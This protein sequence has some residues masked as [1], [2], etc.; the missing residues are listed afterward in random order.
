MGWLNKTL[1]LKLE[2]YPRVLY[3]SAFPIDMRTWHDHFEVTTQETINQ[4]KKRFFFLIWQPP[5]QSYGNAGNR[6]F[7]QEKDKKGENWW[8]IGLNPSDGR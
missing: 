5:D 8:T 4:R 3:K 7:Q 2:L 6:L 1:G